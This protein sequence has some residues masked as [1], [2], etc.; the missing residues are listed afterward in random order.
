[1]SLKISSREKRP[2]CFEVT[3][4]GRLDTNTSPQLEAWLKRFF[5][6]P[7]RWLQFNMAGVEYV[8]S[9]GIRV[10]LVAMKKTKAA[11]GAFMMTELQTPVKKVFDIARVLPRENVFASI[12]EADAYFDEIQK[13]EKKG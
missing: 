2:T 3:L 10:V 4:E 6:Y 7:V 11:G 13:R 5:E 1:M 8:S 12:A 9:A